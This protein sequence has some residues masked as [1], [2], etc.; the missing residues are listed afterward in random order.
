MSLT[1][2]SI[3]NGQQGMVD[4]TFNTYDDGHL[5][6]GFDNIVRTVALQQDGNLIVGGDYLNFN[7][8][9]ATYLCRL[10]PDG[11]IDTGFN[12]DLGLNGKVY[13]SFIQ[14]DGKIIIGG[15]FTTYAGIIANRLIRLNL[16]GSRDITFNS[17]GAGNGIV[18]DVMQQ[19]DG[20]IIIVGSFTQ[21]NGVTVNRVAR[22]LRDGSL[23]TSFATVQDLQRI[24]LIYS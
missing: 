21:Y 4:S 19:P 3:C 6:D 5:E 2:I 13:T 20:K 24:L 11:T 15:A 1:F 23:D 22:I 10:K 9:S 12:S 14:D 8:T 18:Y 16:D 17:N 7:G